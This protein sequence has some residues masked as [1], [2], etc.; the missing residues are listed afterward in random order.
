MIY[1][2]V[3]VERGKKSYRLWLLHLGWSLPTAGAACNTN[4]PFISHGRVTNGACRLHAQPAALISESFEMSNF[5]FRR[6]LLLLL[7]LRAV[8]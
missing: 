6:G 8:T 2:Y 5:L 4:G 1:I 7:L 3:Y